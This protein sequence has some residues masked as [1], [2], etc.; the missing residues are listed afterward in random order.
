MRASIYNSRMARLPTG[1]SSTPAAVR[2]VRYREDLVSAGGRRLIADI[3]LHR[4][5]VELIVLPPPCPLTVAPIDF[6]CA[7]ELIEQAYRDA[8]DFF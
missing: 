5:E 2:Q 8:S 6:S 4:D 7:D 3:E 1:T